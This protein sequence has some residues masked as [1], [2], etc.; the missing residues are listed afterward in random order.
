MVHGGG[1]A[2]LGPGIMKQ[3]AAAS[4]FI[5]R[6]MDMARLARIVLGPFRHEGGHQAVTLGLHLGKGLEQSGLVGCRHGQV[7]VEAGYSYRQFSISRTIYG[8]AARECRSS[9]FVPR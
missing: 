2:A 6:Q 9:K 1:N 4:D 7:L 5:H 8:I 3:L